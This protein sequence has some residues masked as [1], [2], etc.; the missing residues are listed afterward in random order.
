MT[1]SKDRQA[2]SAEGLQLLWQYCGGDG[3]KS[4]QKKLKKA[5]ACLHATGNALAEVNATSKQMEKFCAR[6]NEASSL[7]SL[8]IIIVVVMMT[9]PWLLLKSD[10]C[11]G[12]H[13]YTREIFVQE[14]GF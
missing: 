10:T 1:T 13:K 4:S 2:A 9:T 5:H 14:I 12:R 8:K 6:S 7:L 11:Y 3:E